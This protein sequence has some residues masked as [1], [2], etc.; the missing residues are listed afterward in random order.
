MLMW[1]PYMRIL[2]TLYLIYFCAAALAFLLMLS[3]IQFCKI[4][5]LLV[6]VFTLH[7]IVYHRA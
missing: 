2:P 7:R 4:M 5:Q 3:D 1:L 6:P